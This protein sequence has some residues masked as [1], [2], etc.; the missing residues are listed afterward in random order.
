V[1]RAI[2]LD[3]GDAAAHATLGTVHAHFDWD[4]VAGERELKRALEL[5]PEVPTVLRYYSIFLWHEGRFDEALALNDRELAL[6]P[7]SAFANRNRAIIYYYARRHE[8]CIAQARRTLELD[9]HF[10]TVYGWLGNAYEQLGREREAIEAQ[11]Q[12][13]TF[14]DGRADDVASLRAAGAAGGMR[15]FWRRWLEIEARQPKYPHTHGPV[16]AR[17]K[18]GD[19]RRALEELE[20]LGEERS[21]WARVVGVE[22]QFDP[23]RGDP[24]F[25]AL[26]RKVGLV[27]S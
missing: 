5:G 11:V 22:P 9:P 12:P 10:V 3:P 24:R 27:R 23:L 1:Q 21:P 14:E 15:A 17:L 19:P 4:P 20:K 2:E 26:R 13:F 16:L 7:T 18:A 6:D 25:Q 8:D